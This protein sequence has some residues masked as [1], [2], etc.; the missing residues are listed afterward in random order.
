MGTTLGKGKVRVDGDFDY[1][2]HAS[3]KVMTASLEQSSVHGQEVGDLKHVKPRRGLCSTGDFFSCSPHESFSIAE[4]VITSAIEM[5]D[6]LHAERD[7]SDKLWTGFQGRPPLLDLF[8]AESLDEVFGKLML[9]T[10]Q[11]AKTVALEETLQEVQAPVQIFGD[12]HGQFRDLLYW[13]ED[14]GWPHS[15]GP[16][17]IFNGDW[18]DRGA[19]QVETVSLIFALKLS[20]PDKVFLIRGNHEFRDQ[21]THMGKLGFAAACNVFG[22]Q[23]GTIFDAFHD[24]FDVLPLGCLVSGKILVVHGGLGDGD[25]DLEHLAETTRPITEE[26]CSSDTVVYNVLWS[27]PLPETQEDSFGVHDSPR[28]GHRHLILSFGKDVTE[29]FCA[30]NDIE[31]VVRSHQEKK[32]G[33]GYEVM[34]SGRLVR[35][36]SARDY[37]GHSNDGAI[38]DVR[39]SR[40]KKLVVRAK[41]LRSLTKVAQG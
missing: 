25:W 38:L 2:D 41:L 36:F 33:C 22:D 17:F 39:L 40:G 29:Q 18:V 13:F 20:F 5:A 15:S 34:H 26:D 31:M 37:E 27:D 28:D 3:R 32:G 35:V 1:V 24:V 9:M 21:N 16:S 10:S 8:E 4:D 6:E 23:S 7:V 11:L 30:R 14:F 19:H 12:L